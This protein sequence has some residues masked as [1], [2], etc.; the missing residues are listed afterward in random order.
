MAMFSK[1]ILLEQHKEPAFSHTLVRFVSPQ[2]VSPLQD[3]SPVQYIGTLS[4]EEILELARAARIVDESDG[5]L[6]YR[7]L[8]RSKRKIDTVVADA[9]D[10]EPYVSSKLSPLMQLQDEMLGG[11]MLC[12]NATGAQQQRILIY[13][14][15][16]DL[17]TYIPRRIGNIAVHRLRGGYPAITSSYSARN[18]SRRLA[19]STG[20]LIHLYRAATRNIPQT[21]VFL[22]VAGNCV[23]HPMNMEVSIGTTITQVLERCGLTDTPTR[24]VCGGP[25]KGIAI[26][27][28]DHTLVTHNTRAV[29]AFH[30]SDREYR[31]SCIGCGRCEMSCPAGLNP[32]YIH[33]FIENRYYKGLKDFDAHLC[34]G[35]GTCSYVCPSRLNVVG[36][37]HKAKEYAEEHFP[38]ARKEEDLEI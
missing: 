21:T 34:I 38:I 29:L 12:C 7:K 1:G 22:T 28:S 4:P 37:M 23:A 8:Q 26:I 20:A 30:Q 32:M 27:D 2:S 6:L 33:R 18:K 25:M 16:T 17:K 31:Y 13:R 5:I 35:C 24:V 11:L 10:D 14:N 15:I 9:I 3:R 36:S 19:V